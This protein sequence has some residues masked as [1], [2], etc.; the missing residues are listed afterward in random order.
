MF[1]CTSSVFNFFQQIE[2]AIAPL[3]PEINSLGDNYKILRAFRS[4]VVAS[5]PS[6]IVES[7]FVGKV[8]P[9]SLA[10]MFLF[11]FSPSEIPSPH[12]VRILFLIK[13]NCFLIHE[14]NSLNIFH[15]HRAVTGL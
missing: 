10:L 5:E 1:D 8:V 9:Y 3:C 2:I 13:M 12:E 14:L 6:Q 11:S 15:L 7:E 4:L